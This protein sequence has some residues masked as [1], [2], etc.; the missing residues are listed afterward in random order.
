VQ[1]HMLP[2]PFSKAREGLSPSV[3]DPCPSQRP[4]KKPATAGFFHCRGLLDFG[5]SAG[6]ITKLIT[7][8]GVELFAQVLY[9]IGAVNDAQSTILST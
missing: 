2:I 5:K 3:L 6:L 9:R 8:R 4:L 1:L 7:A